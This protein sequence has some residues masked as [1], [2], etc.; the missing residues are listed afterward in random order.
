MANVWTEMCQPVPF[1]DRAFS[2]QKGT[3][4]KLLVGSYYT[5]GGP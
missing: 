3:A 1:A 5:V 4:T 2:L